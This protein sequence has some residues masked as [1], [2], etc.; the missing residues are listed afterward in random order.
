MAGCLARSV[1]PLNICC[2]SLSSFLSRTYILP[3]CSPVLFFYPF[4]SLSSS[5]VHS[6][7]PLPLSPLFHRSFISFQIPVHQHTSCTIQSPSLPSH[8]HHKTIPSHELSRRGPASCL[9]FQFTLTLS[10]SQP[11]SQRAER[12]E[13][14]LY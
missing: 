11:P 10:S 7:L 14:L 6:F 1:F 12:W 5:P 8:N 9:I 3:T 4:L 2:S 13:R